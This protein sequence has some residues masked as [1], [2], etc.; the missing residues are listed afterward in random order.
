M[1]RCIAFTYLALVLES[2]SIA[3]PQ[4]QSPRF[5]VA[6]IKPVDKRVRMGY[7]EDAG[8]ISWTR[9]PLTNLIA[10]AYGVHLDQIT[11]PDWLKTEFYAIT[12]KLPPGATRD[13]YPQ[14]MAN[15]LADRFGLI[16]HRITKDVP[17]YELVLSPGGPKNLNPANAEAAAVTP[18]GDF[19]RGGLKPDPNGFP[20]LAPGITWAARSDDG[21][22]KMTFGAGSMAG[23]AAQLRSVLSQTGSGETI[24]VTDRTG[25]AG[26][27]DFHLAIP[28]TGKW[29]P[30]Q[31]REQT[32]E[33]GGRDISAALEKQLG[34]KLNA[35]KTKLDFIVVD[36]VN[37]VPTDN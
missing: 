19:G 6:S 11:G 28:A 32:P 20:V 31:V 16:V 1:L 15:L 26:K 33:V 7:S 25:I 14:M 8:Q 5:E 30:P 2:V 17:G 9:I 12:A 24:P 34:L 22:M 18:P 4:D 29:L 37:N 35:V 36:H 21:M 27:F 23:L 3:A 13:Q 10:D